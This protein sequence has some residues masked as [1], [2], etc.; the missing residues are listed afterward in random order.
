MNNSSMNITVERSTRVSR[1][2]TIVFCVA[3]VV[4]AGA[5]WWCPRG[6][7]SM[8]VE[9]LYYLALAELWNLLA[10]YAGVMS[11]GSQ[12]FIGLGGYSLFF[13]ALLRG[14]HPLIAL[15]LAGVVGLLVALP[16]VALILRL[17]GA[18]LAIASW[19]V[20]EVG[21][22]AFTEVEALGR[23]S[24]KSLEVSIVRKLEF[25]FLTRDGTLYLLA[26]V[27]AILTI[28]LSYRLLCSKYG[29]ALTSVRDNETSARSSGVNSFGLKFGVF[30]VTGAAMA[31]VGALIYL[32]KLR[33]SPASAFDINWTSNIIFIVIIGGIGTLE[34]PIVGTIVFFVLRQY[35]SDLGSW[36]LII[37]GALAVAIMLK[38]PRGLWG[39]FSSRF[40]VRLFPTRRCLVFL[41]S[42][43]ANAG[44]TNTRESALAAGSGEQS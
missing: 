11:L 38:M 9:F 26:L 1:V 27:I 25:P 10:G 36:Y 6:Q 34:G 23:G 35:L 21:R 16:A 15:V 41:T 39:A 44:S 14:W 5:P 3:I 30:V 31:L 17:H 28:A 33:I 42:D 7:L 2:S 13:F 22:L 32:T 12:G 43:H 8:L 29:L 19:V 4:L 24:G 40:D 20:A 18:Y 37:L